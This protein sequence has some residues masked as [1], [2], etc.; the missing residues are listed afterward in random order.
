MN[1]FDIVGP[2]MVGPSSSHTAGAVRIGLVS[3]KLAGEHFHKAEILLHGSFALSGKGHGTDKALVAGLLGLDVSDP[4]IPNAFEVAQEAGLD[5][6]FGT[7]DLGEKAHPNSVQI[8]ITSD[9]GT[10]TTVVSSSI[11]AGRIMVNTINNMPVEFT[12]EYPTLIITNSDQPGC[13]ADVSAFLHKAGINIA[14]LSLH[15]DGRG[16][17]AVMIIE[18]DEEVYP[19][20]VDKLRALNGIKK[21]TYYSPV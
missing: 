12:G 8:T 1:L 20:S 7:I 4:R 16:K 11:G 19:K 2:V 6:T 9:D 5:F 3:R 21:V 14:N 17:N 15:R 18:C 13:V 10:T